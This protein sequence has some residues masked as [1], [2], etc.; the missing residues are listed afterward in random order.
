VVVVALAGVV[1]VVVVVVVGYEEEKGREGL[2][3]RQIET[4][5]ATCDHTSLC[6]VTRCM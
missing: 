6:R 1:V 2:G 3:A 5:T 4:A